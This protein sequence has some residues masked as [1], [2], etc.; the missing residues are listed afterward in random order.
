MAR[1]RNLAS[2]NTWAIAIIAWQ[3][4]FTGV[5]IALSVAGHPLLWVL[6]QT[7]LAISLFQWFVLHHDL[8]HG[9]FF[10]TRWLNALFGHVSSA[11]CLMPFFSWRQVHHHHHIWTG[12]KDKD[13]SDPHS[14]IR[15]PSPAVLRAINFCWRYWI[16][17]IA[18]SFVAINFWNLK[19]VNTL[20]PDPASR[21]KNLFSVVFL[22]VVYAVAI[23]VLRSAMLVHW[24]PAI[25]LFLSLSDPIL[26]TQH[27]H[28]DANYARG[29]K[30]KAFRFAEQGAYSRNVIYPR[31]V[32]KYFFYNSE[33]HGLHHVHPE[34]PVYRLGRL[35]SPPENTITW[36][37]WLSTAKR[38]PADV[39][40]F[41]TARESGVK[42]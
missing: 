36:S 16:P 13:P 41:Q 34:V 39:L 27:A 40:I 21:R 33:R 18:I 6:G 2:S 30:V 23:G 37:D 7:L 10:R 20:F 15:N 35:P 26:L 25:L 29:A 24:L 28:I 14:Q 32:A 1:D 11:F 4:T 17:V 22:V 3:L 8:A 38:M 5:A 31:W 12:W 42:L 19:R 9:G